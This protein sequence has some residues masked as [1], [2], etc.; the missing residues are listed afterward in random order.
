MYLRYLLWY[1]TLKQFGNII[2]FNVLKN[3]H[4]DLKACAKLLVFSV[5]LFLCQCYPVLAYIHIIKRDPRAYDFWTP[6]YPRGSYVITPVCPLVR[7]LV[8]RLVRPSL[9]ISET[10]HYFILIFYMKLLHHKGTK[11]TEPD[12]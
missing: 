2:T 1:M 7:P 6:V 11:M 10:V 4:I 8:R 9:D 3:S 5:K 12:F